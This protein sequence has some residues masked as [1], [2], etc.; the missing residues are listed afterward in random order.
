MGILPPP[1]FWEGFL[2]KLTWYAARIIAGCT[3]A[4]NATVL[5]MDHHEEPWRVISEL[6]VTPIIFWTATRGRP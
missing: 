2:D 5:N 6:V 3:L 4:I 1:T